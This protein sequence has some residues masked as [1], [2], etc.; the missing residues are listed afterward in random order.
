MRA[1]DE[2]ERPEPEDPALS[3]GR[4]TLLIVPAE[5]VGAIEGMVALS[6][7]A[8]DFVALMRRFDDARVTALRGTGEVTVEPASSHGVHLHISRY[9]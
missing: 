8:D 9:E 2:A 6:F 7:V 5:E 3:V 1:R 4:G